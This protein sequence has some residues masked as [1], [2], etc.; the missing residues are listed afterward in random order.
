[1]NSARSSRHS[2]LTVLAN[3]AR[4]YAAGRLGRGPKGSHSCT[5]FVR[6]PLRPYPE[7]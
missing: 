6:T 1:M 4:T 2:I 3:R 5:D 7:G